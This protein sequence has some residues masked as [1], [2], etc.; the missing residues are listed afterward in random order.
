MILSLV[1]A[2]KAAWKLLE[3]LKITVLCQNVEFARISALTVD[4]FETGRVQIGIK[5]LRLWNKN[6]NK[7]TLKNGLLR[8]IINRIIGKIRLITNG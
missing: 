3:F 5:G 1:T 8:W 7:D 2:F 6:Q 4:K